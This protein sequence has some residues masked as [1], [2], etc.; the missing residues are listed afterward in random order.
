MYSNIL[1]EEARPDDPIRNDL[2]LIAEQANRC[3]NIVGGLLNFARKNQ[4]RYTEVDIYDFVRHSIESVIIP[5][6]VTVEINSR[7][8]DNKVMIDPDQM[9]QVLTNL[10]KNAVEAMPDGGKLKIELSGNDEEVKIDVSDT[11]IGI[12]AENMDKI[13][14]PFFTTKKPGKGTGLGLPLIYGI[15]KMHKG[16]I[17]VESNQDA[18]K[19]PLGTSFKISLPRKNITERINI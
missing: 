19:G 5:E 13:F 8:N 2:E 15:V 7:L 9:M 1:R 16:N 17:H 3:K 12:S 6:N 14:T 18:L 10:E 4:V 11:G